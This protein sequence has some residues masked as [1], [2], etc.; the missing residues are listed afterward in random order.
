MNV[1]IG[2]CNDSTESITAR[3]AIIRRVRAIT[4]GQVL[5]RQYLVNLHLLAQPLIIAGQSFIYTIVRQF[6]VFSGIHDAGICCNGEGIKG[7]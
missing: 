7:N 3:L 5:V 4:G 1:V 2:G 6:R